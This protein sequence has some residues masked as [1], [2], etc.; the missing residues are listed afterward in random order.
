MAIIVYA[1]AF[2]GSAFTL[3][4]APK[5]EIKCGNCGHTFLKRIVLAKQ[6][7]AICDH[8]SAVNRFRRVEYC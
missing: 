8:C 5:W 7:Y 6:P 2:E 4:G 3:F 1:K